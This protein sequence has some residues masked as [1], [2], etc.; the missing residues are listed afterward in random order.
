MLPRLKNKP[1]K[2]SE[3][4]PSSNQHSSLGWTCAVK[5]VHG[6]FRRNPVKSPPLTAS[7]PEPVRTIHSPAGVR[8]RCLLLR[9]PR[10]RAER[11][12]R[13]LHRGLCRM[14]D[15]LQTEPTGIGH[16]HLGKAFHK[17][18]AIQALEHQRFA[19]HRYRVK[20]VA[21]GQHG[22]RISQAANFRR[23]RPV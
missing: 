22:S 17:D 19:C 7:P 11:H 20:P 21:L 18:V 15:H 6:W 3:W 12:P 14:A 8:R 9:R 13:G 23:Q 1:R 16:F 10:T 2:D 4:C 5:R